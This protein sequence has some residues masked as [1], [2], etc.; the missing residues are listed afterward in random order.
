MYICTKP[1][2][3]KNPVIAS[4]G[5]RT[6]NLRLRRPTLYPIELRTPIAGIVSLLT[7]NVK[8]REEQSGRTAGCLYSHAIFAGH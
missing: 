2:Y 6:H 4:G 1:P 8:Q 3:N 5:A 7:R